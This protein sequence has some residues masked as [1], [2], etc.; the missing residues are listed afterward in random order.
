MTGVLIGVQEGFTKFYCFLL[1]CGSHSTTERYIKRDWEPGKALASA[2]DSFQH[3]P[4]DNSS[5]IF[6]PP[7]QINLELF[8]CLVKTVG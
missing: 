8:K 3:I 2:K 7:L 5:M 6:L 4:L 1:L